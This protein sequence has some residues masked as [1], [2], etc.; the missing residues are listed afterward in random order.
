MFDSLFIGRVYAKAML[1][2]R[3]RNLLFDDFDYENTKE[4]LKKCGFND[5][6]IKLTWNYFGGKP[7]HL[8]KAI[9]NR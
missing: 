4:F 9:R 2:G 3:C 5:E 7:V 1:Q 8:V 6:K